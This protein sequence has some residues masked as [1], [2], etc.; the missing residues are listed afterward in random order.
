MSQ[1]NPQTTR[2][3][4]Y[5]MDISG[6]RLQQ[7]AD[8]G[9]VKPIKRGTWELVD[10]LH[11]YIRYLRDGMKGPEDTHDARRERARLLKAQ[12]D[13]T[14]LEAAIL[15]AD[16]I[17]AETVQVVWTQILGACRARL[18]SLPPRLAAVALSAN[19]Y[20]D[21]ET[22]ARE[23][24]DEALNELADFNPETYR[25]ERSRAAHLFSSDTNLASAAEI[26]DQRVGESTPAT[27]PRR[28]RRTGAVSH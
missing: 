26:V 1:S 18:L 20:A 13:K 3:M 8:E 22:H 11:G 15:R 21:V 17:P 19:S 27:V 24:V 4:S 6:R 2:T 14:E 16:V 23:L 25:T 28:Q 7:L 10:T 9:V 12:A 5:L